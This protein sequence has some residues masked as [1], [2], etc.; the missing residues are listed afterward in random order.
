M[1]AI[2]LVS[3][4]QSSEKM[5]WKNVM[6]TVSFVLYKQT[7]KMSKRLTGFPKAAER[8]TS[9]TRNEPCILMFSSRIIT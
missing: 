6:P 9:G 1:L 8:V 5:F 2:F 7:K 3:F 4:I